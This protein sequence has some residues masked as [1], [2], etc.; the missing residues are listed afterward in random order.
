MGMFIID[1]DPGMGFYCADIDDNLAILFALRA[2]LNVGLITL[3][4]GNVRAGEAYKSISTFLALAG[5]RGIPIAVGG[6]TTLSGPIKTGQERIRSFLQ[7]VGIGCP[8]DSENEISV[9][10]PLFP[11]LPTPAPLALLETVRQAGSGEVTILA[12]GPLTNIALAILLDSE[13][14]RRI[15]QIIVMGGAFDN[16][17]SSIPPIEF[18]IQTDPE[19]AAIVLDSGIPLT[20][21]PLD[22][23]MKVSYCLDELKDVFGQPSA[24]NNFI[25]TWC[26]QWSKVSKQVFGSGC[27]VPHDCVAVGYVLR[28]DLYEVKTARV[29]VELFGRFTR[30]ETLILPSSQPAKNEGTIRVCTNI[31]VRA[32]KSY[33]AELMAIGSERGSQE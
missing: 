24:L 2:G 19:A 26:E 4:S 3:V 12:L 32:F 14:M 8:G 29:R 23:T 5:Y 22:V 16:L 31:N 9:P 6:E 17:S 25:L 1:T 27:I 28:P 10:S 7:K 15:G 30:G 18:N 20:L 33:F 11:A 13:T 21:V